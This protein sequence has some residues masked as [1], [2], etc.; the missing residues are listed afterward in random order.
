MYWNYSPFARSL[1]NEIRIR[2]NTNMTDIWSALNQSNCYLQKLTNQ[3]RENLYVK[4]SCE[5]VGAECLIKRSAHKN[6]I[7]CESEKCIDLKSNIQLFWSFFTLTYRSLDMWLL[8]Y[9]HRWVNNTHK[10]QLLLISLITV[11]HYF[12]RRNLLTKIH[13]FLKV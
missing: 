6:R 7:V 10:I 11:V 4:W 8:Q 13:D 12:I 9:D 3:V 1:L 5:K 2:I